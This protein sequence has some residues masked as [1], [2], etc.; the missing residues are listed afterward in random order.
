MRCIGLTVASVVLAGCVNFSALPEPG[1]LTNPALPDI[2]VNWQTDTSGTGPAPVGWIDELGDGTLVALVE[3]AQENNRTLQ[4]VLASVEQS[5]AILRQARSSLFPAINYSASGS[6]AGLVD[7]PSAESYAS[8]L[9]LNWELDLWGRVRASRNAAAFAAQATEAD[10]RFA[11]YSLAAGVARAYFGVIEASLQLAVAQKS[12]DA[13]SRTAK[14]VSTQR[15][16]GAADAYDESLALANVA[17]ARASLAQAEGG[18]RLAKRALSVLLGRYPDELLSIRDDFPI[19]PAIPTAGLPGE[20]LERRPDIIA[21]ELTVLSAFSDVGATK[22]TRLPTFSLSGGLNVSS[23]EFSDVLDVS[24]G[25]WS[26][27]TALLGP[28]FDAGLRRAQIDAASAVQTQAIALYAQT[29]L[30]AFEEVENSLDQNRVIEVRV[31]ALTDAAAAQN[32]AFD[33]AEF[34]YQEGETNLLDVLVVQSNTLTADSALVSV[35][36]E[37]LDE[38]INL[39][40]A[41]GGTWQV[42]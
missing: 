21:A 5:R 9:S 32:K 26:L 41:L 25:T 17:S 4:S 20:L 6:E 11:Q 40:L 22:A 10:Y 27:A 38:W 28:L 23:P 42:P 36:R 13:L 3:E 35:Q 7:G 16:F 15:E 8:G 31:A 34:R 33:L 1:E 12:L 29:A 24:N 18:L 37:Q 14:I 2:P 19:R 30:E 39:N